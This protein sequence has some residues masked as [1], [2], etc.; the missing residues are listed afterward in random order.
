MYLWDTDTCIYFLKGDKAITEAVKETG[1]ET[2]YTT[3]ISIAELKFGAYNS[4]YAYPIDTGCI[5]R[6]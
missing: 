2:I 5:F 6:V 3:I 4:N 1:V